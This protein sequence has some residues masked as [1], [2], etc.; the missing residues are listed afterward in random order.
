MG[1]YHPHGDA[2]L[3]GTLVRMAQPF[4]MRYCLVDGHGNFGDVDGDE[5]AAMRYTEA[6]MTKLA[7]EMIRD[8]DKD[9][10]DFMDNYDGTEREPA[11]LPARFPN[12][13][14]NG[15]EG[16]AVGMATNMPTHNL[17]EAINATIAVARNPEITPLELMQN[18]IYGPDFPTGG[19]I[20][21]RQG[22]LDYFTTGTGS[23][24]IRSKYH[25]E[26]NA[27]GK[28]SIIVTEI[29][30]Q[31]NKAAMIEN[32]ASLVR[33][34]VIDGITDIRD[35]SSKEGVRV[36]IEVRRDAIPEVVANNL[37]K[38]TQLQISYGVINLCLVGGEPKILGIVPMIQAYIDH[39][40]E[41]L[42]RR[43]KFLLK[44]DTDRDHIVTGLIL[45]HDNIDE[46]IHIIR[47]SKTD[48]ES[49][50][51]L[52]EAFG[53]SKPQTD[54]IL[55]M[56]LRRLEGLEQEKLQNEHHEL[57]KNIEHYNWLLSDRENIL[58]M[59]IDELT[60]VK[61]KFGDDRLTEISNEAANIDNEDLLPQENILV[62]LTKKGYVKRMSDNTF[63]TQNR[64]GR[65][66]KGITTTAGDLVQLMLHTKTHTD[67]MFFSS[68]GFVY[69]LRGYMIPDGERNSK[70][71]PAVNLLNLA[72]DEKI[73]AIVPCDDYPE[74][75]YLFFTTVNGV[76]KRTKL[77]EFASIHS[78]GKRAITLK[79]GDELLDVKRTHGNDIISL[80]SSNG[81]VCSFHEEEVRAMGRTAAGVTGMNLKDGSHL[82]DVTGSMEGKL[83][84][85][86]SANGL[87]KLSYCAD[88]DVVNEDGSTTH[89]DGYRLTSRGAKGVFSLKMN[90]KNGGLTAMRAVNGDEDLMV[91]TNKGIVIRTPLSQI[92]IAG[93]NTVGV[94]IIALDPGN[95]V[96]SL[97]IVPHIDEDA[98]D[99]VVEDDEI[100]PSLLS[101]EERE[102]SVSN[103]TPDDVEEGD[104][105]NEPN[106]TPDDVE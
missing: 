27:S 1:K 88:T 98:E 83:I 81:K 103:P 29:P 35:E 86:L 102:T 49:A 30:Y 71:I 84:L 50:A 70:G 39:Q 106:P 95:R 48:E 28:A 55:A 7:V 3:Y 12:L 38:H 89:Y 5:A 4:A 85:V 68:L 15:S 36:V 79:E 47:G 32:M 45:A 66:V 97:A 65:G 18:Y 64:G 99:E 25:V 44:R 63:R 19:V 69:R 31:V 41:V 9:T 96:A 51:K 67:I 54:A 40:M 80:A 26:E 90:G 91:I 82:V 20:L 46:V 24:A 60:E 17:T 53:L 104:N 58:A 2:A 21:G 105:S 33:D 78:N 62:V 61:N 75:D 76:V 101:E 11:V 22:I 77:T 87:G 72:Q 74:S 8:L 42:T 100:N 93:R 94:K 10:V 23:V 16:I 14:V 73:V 57:T 43:T 13:L 59:M 52:N 92:H 34:K 6:R 56:T 37:L